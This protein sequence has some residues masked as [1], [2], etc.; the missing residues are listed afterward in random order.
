MENKKINKIIIDLWQRNFSNDSKVYAPLFYGNFIKNSILFVG[1]NP[2]FSQVSFAR[3][4]RGT[5][6]EKIKPLSFFKW[7][8]ISKDWKNVEKLISIEKY[9]IEKYARFFGPLRNI[10]EEVKLPFQHADLFLYRQTSQREFYK[11]I[12]KKSKINKFGLDQVDI[13]KKVINEAQPKII[14]VA[15]AFASRVIQDKFKNLISNF[16]RKKGFHWFSL[17]NKRKIPIFFS[18]MITGQRALDVYSRKRLGWHI[19]QAVKYLK[20]GTMPK[21]QKITTPKVKL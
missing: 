15:N 13:F 9:A 17:D 7:S 16:D 10:A 2:A 19:G 11:R 1:C 5:E 8:N 14:V 6:Y 21:E 12:F 4:L 18:S 20:K 3:I